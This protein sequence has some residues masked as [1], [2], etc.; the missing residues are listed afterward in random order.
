VKCNEIS[1]KQ[2]IMLFFLP[3]ISVMGKRNLIYN[4]SGAKSSD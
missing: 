4:T 3:D 1:A 2:Q